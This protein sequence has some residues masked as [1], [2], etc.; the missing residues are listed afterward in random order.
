MLTKYYSLNDKIEW[1]FNQGAPKRHIVTEQNV[2]LTELCR[3]KQGKLYR[4]DKYHG[5]FRLIDGDREDEVIRQHIG[6]NNYLSPEEVAEVLAESQAGH[7]AQHEEAMAQYRTDL[8]EILAYYQQDPYCG[9]SEMMKAI[10]LREDLISKPEPIRV[11]DP[12]DL[13]EEEFQ[14]LGDFFP[15]KKESK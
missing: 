8:E 13:M 12:D 6:S 11:P 7:D 4:P 3:D 10:L 15:K 2:M 14:S 5:G 9:Y 1:W